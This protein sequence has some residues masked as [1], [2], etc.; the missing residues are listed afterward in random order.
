MSSALQ[1]EDRASIPGETKAPTA[2][3]EGWHWLSNAPKWHYFAAGG[4]SLC[5]RWMTFGRTFEQGNDGSP[6][7][8]ADCRK[9]VAKRKATTAA[10]ST[11][12]G[13]GQ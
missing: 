6:D 2:P 13:G 9:R 1:P 12:G 3:T 10:G 8:C 11:L 4:R 7:N 5:G